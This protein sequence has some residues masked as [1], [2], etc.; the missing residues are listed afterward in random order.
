M[1]GPSGPRGHPRRLRTQVG[2]AL[3]W[4]F[5]AQVSLG[6]LLAF[7][8]NLNGLFKLKITQFNKNSF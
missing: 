2:P 6:D 1:I 5:W 4:L 8:F 7:V 3:V